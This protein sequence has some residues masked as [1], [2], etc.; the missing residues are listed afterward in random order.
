M[1]LFYFH[2][3]GRLCSDL[4]AS[5]SGKDVPEDVRQKMLG[6]HEENISLKEQYKTSQEKLTKAK[7]FIKQQD[8][9]FKEEHAKSTSSIPSVSFPAHCS[10]YNISS[11]RFHLGRIRRSR[12]Q[13]PLT[14]QDI[15]G[16]S[17]SREG[18]CHA[19][20]SMRSV[21]TFS[22]FRD[23]SPRRPT[24]TAEKPV[25]CSASSTRKV[26]VLHGISLDMRSSKAS[27]NL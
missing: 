16:R 2:L 8:K 26:C 24:A 21:L 5:L 11:H 20:E 13:L 10:S 14:N 22:F 12:E 17:C 4:R 1:W 23:S 3:T 19:R 25:S 9:L 7:A 18:N 6:L 27:Q 15:G